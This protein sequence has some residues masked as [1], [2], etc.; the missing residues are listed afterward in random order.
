MHCSS[1]TR[2]IASFILVLLLMGCGQKWSQSEKDNAQHFIQSVRL[3]VQAHAI[4]NQGKPGIMSEDD[5]ATISGLYK[6]A[7]SEANLVTDEVLE[8]ANPDLPTEYRQYFQKGVELRI[9][10]WE[11]RNVGDE[12]KGSGLLDA[13]GEWYQ[14]NRQNIKIPQ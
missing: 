6:N 7:L 9:S 13:W 14:Q 3:V 4:D 1:A 11:K 5:F 12:I 2:F 10:S 8:K